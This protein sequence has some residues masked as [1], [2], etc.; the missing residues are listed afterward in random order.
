MIGPGPRAK[1]GRATFEPDYDFQED[2]IAKAY[3]SS[4][5]NLEYLGDWHSHPDGSFH[6]SETDVRV[7]RKI[8]GHAA[9]RCQNPVM[10]ILSGGP[11]W[12]ASAWRL[13]NGRC[14][15]IGVDSIPAE[16]RNVRAKKPRRLRLIR[17][18]WRVLW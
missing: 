12:A 3:A 2:E 6:P 18:V 8:A 13:E 5:E 4:G 17:N 10:F 1:H 15:E 11:Q 16:G 7:L 14:I 9:A